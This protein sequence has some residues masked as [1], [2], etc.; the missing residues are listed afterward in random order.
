MTSGGIA[1]TEQ[2]VTGS[3]ANTS[4]SREA[5]LEAAGLDSEGEDDVIDANSKEAEG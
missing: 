2:A 5:I 1:A 3:K 4:K